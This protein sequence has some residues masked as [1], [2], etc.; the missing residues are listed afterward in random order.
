MSLYYLLQ[1]QNAIIQCVSRKTLAQKIMFYF[2]KKRDRKVK[3]K[4]CVS[5]KL[6][7]T[8][9]LYFLWLKSVNN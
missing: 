8:I 2:K 6:S 4:S 7:T 3:F 9:L 5:Q 1:L